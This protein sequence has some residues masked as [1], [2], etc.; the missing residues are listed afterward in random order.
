MK[1]STWHA[2]EGLFLLMTY[3]AVALL[4]RCGE[5]ARTYDLTSTK[6]RIGYWAI[7]AYVTG[8]LP[9]HLVFLLTGLTLRRR[10]ADAPPAPALLQCEPIRAEGAYGHHPAAAGRRGV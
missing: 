1:S 3:C 4:A 9:G 7:T 2:E 5:F 6:R 8:S 10:P